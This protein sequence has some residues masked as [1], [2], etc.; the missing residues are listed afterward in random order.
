MEMRNACKILVGKP[1]GIHTRKR[2]WGFNIKMKLKELNLDVWI[3]FIWLGIG[4]SGGLL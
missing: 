1:E 3:G 4:F 2:R